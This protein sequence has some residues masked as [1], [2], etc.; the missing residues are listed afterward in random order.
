LTQLEEFKAEM[1]AL[2]K[3][4]PDGAI[5]SVVIESLPADL[6]VRLCRR[7]GTRRDRI[8]DRSIIYAHSSSR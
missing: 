8:A 2:F 6:A 1:A 3:L 5:H 7:H 4:L